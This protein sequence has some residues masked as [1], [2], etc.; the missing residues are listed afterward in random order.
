MAGEFKVIIKLNYPVVSQ[1]IRDFIFFKPN[2]QITLGPLESNN[3]TT[4]NFRGDKISP[5]YHYA[6]VLSAMIT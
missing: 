3:E 6:V 5:L 1:N 4:T 2:L